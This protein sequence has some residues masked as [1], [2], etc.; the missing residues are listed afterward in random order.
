L[1][2]PPDVTVG[3]TVTPVHE[4][5]VAAPIVAPVNV[6]VVEP[7]VRAAAKVAVTVA[8]PVGVA[9]LVPH[10]AVG[11]KPTAVA[12]VMKPAGIV[13]TTVSPTARLVAVVKP[14]TIL[15]PVAPGLRL[16]GAKVTPE[17]WP[18]HNV[19]AALKIA[20]NVT[21]LTPSMLLFEVAA[22]VEMVTPV[23]AAA[24]A[25]AFFSPANRH[26]IDEAVAVAGVVTLSTRVL[27]PDSDAVPA[28]RPLQV[29]EPVG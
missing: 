14:T 7:A 4:E 24:A 15:V 3:P 11:R 6:S 28:E 26:T 8:V 22:K 12:V 23:V 21:K 9:V 1:T 25:A 20:G 2:P 18:L 16:A 10:V 17:T 29:R 13:M 19:S 5:P 27:E